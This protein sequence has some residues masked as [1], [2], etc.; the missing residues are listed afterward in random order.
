LTALRELPDQLGGYADDFGGAL[1]HGS[2]LQAEAL[3]EEV[4]EVGLIEVAGGSGVLEEACR[5][6]RAPHEPPLGVL[7][8]S[9]VRGHDV[10]VEEGVARPAGSV[11][12]RSGDDTV[13]G[14]KPTIAAAGASEDGSVFVVA[15]D[16]VDRLAMRLANRGSLLVTGQGP[17]DAHALRGPQGQVVARTEPCCAS[18]G[19]ESVELF[20]RYR[21]RVAPDLPIPCL[22]SAEEIRRRFGHDVVVA[23]LLESTSI[24]LTLAQEPTHILPGDA[25]IRR[26]T[27]RLDISSRAFRSTRRRAC[28][29]MMDQHLFRVGVPTGEHSSEV[30]R[31]HGA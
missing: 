16:L 18:T 12:E 30:L 21:P 29:A 24:P 25:E 20:A 23:R 7:H 22:A 14:E 11:V 27:S 1:D 17:E 15:H 26:G 8:A 31:V 19:D 3:G 13:A 10:G 5:G 4:A 6:N 9:H 2:E 28:C